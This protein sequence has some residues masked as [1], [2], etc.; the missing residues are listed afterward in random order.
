MFLLV[1]GVQVCVVC[2]S[3]FWVVVG[4]SGSFLVVSVARVLC[5]ILTSSGCFQVLKLG[6]RFFWAVWIGLDCSG[7]FLLLFQVVLGCFG[8]VL[9]VFGGLKLFMFLCVGSDC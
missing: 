1:S 4:C 3:L 9:V 8:V 5:D 7:C 6:V 2:V